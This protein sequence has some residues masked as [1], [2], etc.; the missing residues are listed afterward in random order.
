M[1]KAK[2]ALQTDAEKDEAVRAAQEAAQWAREERERQNKQRLHEYVSNEFARGF[3]LKKGG[4]KGMMGRHNWKKRWFVIR[5]SQAT[6]YAKKGDSKP[7]GMIDLSHCKVVAVSRPA[8]E[9]KGQFQF[10]VH[11]VSEKGGGSGG[12]GGS[13]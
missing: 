10:D 9:K 7:K 12:S 6:Y 2:E 13:G 4:G 8:K 11:A 3:L 1:Q 5:G